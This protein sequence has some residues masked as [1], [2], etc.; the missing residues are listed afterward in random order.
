MLSGAYLMTYSAPIVV[1]GHPSRSVAHIAEVASSNATAT[2]D[3]HRSLLA[4]VGVGLLVSA[5]AMGWSV[6]RRRPTAEPP[7]TPQLSESAAVL[8]HLGASR[9]DGH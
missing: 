1:G 3:D 4:A 9:P 7:P 5:V 6:S 8:G 2:L